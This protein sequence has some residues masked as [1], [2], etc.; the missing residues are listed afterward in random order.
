MSLRLKNYENVDKKD[1]KI[2][3]NPRNYLSQELNPNNSIIKQPQGESK[4]IIDTKT[5]FNPLSSY[6]DYK[7][8]AKPDNLFNNLNSQNQN[9]RL[10]QNL[11]NPVFNSMPGA[12]NPRPPQSFM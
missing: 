1:F 10:S 11:Q 4:Q 7:N 3:L 6:D 2:K 5:N 9:A 12:Y 8:K